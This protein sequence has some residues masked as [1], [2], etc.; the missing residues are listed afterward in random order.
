MPSCG[1]TQRPR[2]LYRL[3]FDSGEEYVGQ[4]VNVDTR[5]VGHRKRWDDIVTF[6]LFPKPTGDLDGPERQLI[7]RTEA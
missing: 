2:G 3:S 6:E 4:S 1:A 7:T 5:F